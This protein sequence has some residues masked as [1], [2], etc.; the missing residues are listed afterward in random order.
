MMR[1]LSIRPSPNCSTVPHVQHH[2]L[3]VFV[4]ALALPAAGCDDDEPPCREFDQTHLERTLTALTSRKGI[5][6]DPEK[7]GVDKCVR[8][9][10]AKMLE[11]G[12]E[13]SDSLMAAMTKA[14]YAKGW[15][16][17][18]PKVDEFLEAPSASARVAT[19]DALANIAPEILER[20]LGELLNS[21]H[22]DVRSAAA[23]QAARLG[24]RKHIALLT[25]LFVAS[26]E[27]EKK[28]H[29]Q[30][31]IDLRAGTELA[32]YVAKSPGLVMEVVSVMTE[33]SD[34]PQPLLTLLRDKDP[35]IRVAVIPWLGRTV[36]SDPSANAE[37]DA[38]IIRALAL[39]ATDANEAVRLAAQTNLW[40]FAGT[41]E[42][43]QTM[44]VSLLEAEQAVPESKRVAGLCY[45]ID[46]SEA[47]EARLKELS[48][49]K[50]KA[51]KACGKQA[52]KAIK[53][54]KRAAKKS[55]R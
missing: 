50:D 30:A 17:F 49:S 48:K 43:R 41:N 40:T 54:K 37:T 29:R 10:M 4:L 45:G 18:E 3:F 13:L 42:A 15:T 33:S 28:V 14:T 1:W 31:L 32:D 6:K 55:D 35:T 22:G 39:A 44:L 21:N 16:E 2:L 23:R 11:E 5:R 26:E 47:G 51:L 25:N 36:A 34:G 38:T 8:A 53:D 9:A 20:R 52:L 12:A 19:M 46:Y 27:P 7:G 24:A